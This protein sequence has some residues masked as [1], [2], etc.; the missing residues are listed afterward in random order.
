MGHAISANPRLAR[1]PSVRR[2]GGAVF[3]T[4]GQSVDRCCGF[5][6]RSSRWVFPGSVLL[7]FRR[8]YPTQTGGTFELG[9]HHAVDR[10]VRH[11]LCCASRQSVQPSPLATRGV[12]PG[13]G[14]LAV[15]A[16]RLMTEENFPVVTPGPSQTVG[17]ETNGRQAERYEVDPPCS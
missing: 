8:G 11:A 2:F 9:E 13:E 16:K 1:V 15:L 7:W 17:S 6:P 4:Q 10:F 3:G 14:Q 5:G 12:S